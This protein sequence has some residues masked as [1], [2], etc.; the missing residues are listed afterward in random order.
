MPV[1]R[2][3]D[4]QPP[5]LADLPDL[6]HHLERVEEELSLNRVEELDY[7]N[8]VINVAQKVR[9]IREHIRHIRNSLNSVML[10]LSTL[11]NERLI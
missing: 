10:L 11:V 7:E 5:Q 4:D 2:Y 9:V 1:E 6:N 3:I 8:L